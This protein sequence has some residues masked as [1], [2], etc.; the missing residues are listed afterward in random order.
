MT[1]KIDII[2]CFS[3]IC[4]CLTWIWHDKP[5]CINLHSFLHS[6]RIVFLYVQ[7]PALPRPWFF[8]LQ[9]DDSWST[10]LQKETTAVPGISQ[11]DTCQTMTA[12]DVTNMSR[13]KKYPLYPHFFTHVP[14]KDNNVYS[15]IEFSVENREE[16]E[17]WS[18][19]ASRAKCCLL[20]LA[21]LKS[22]SLLS[23][24]ARCHVSACASNYLPRNHFCLFRDKRYLTGAEALLRRLLW[25]CLWEEEQAV[26]WSSNIDVHRMC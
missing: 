22:S 5:I 19:S 14:Y 7:L 11:D 20:F 9:G 10:A 12:N 6:F 21:F 26:C 17:T 15:A 4:A 25:Q 1:L 2:C 8:R 13:S 24:Q 18:N 3:D 16:A 23:Q